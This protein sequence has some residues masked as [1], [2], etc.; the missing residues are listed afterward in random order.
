VGMWGRKIGRVWNGVVGLWW[1]GRECLEIGC[2]WVSK[3][4]KE[5]VGWGSWTSERRWLGKLRVGGLLV[6][7]GRGAGRVWRGVVEL[8][9]GRDW[10]F[11]WWV[12][13]GQ[14]GEGGW[15]SVGWGG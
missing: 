2:G 6:S 7:W 12:G 5:S 8:R 3:G 11:L 4:G 15:K 9:W 13:V 1:G 14:L 10:V